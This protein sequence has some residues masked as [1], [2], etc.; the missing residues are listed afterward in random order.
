MFKYATMYGIV[1]GI[2]LI[3]WLTFDYMMGYYGQNKTMSN[4]NYLARI[5][6]T[7]ICIFIY[8]N[9]VCG[10]YIS[11][12]KAFIFGTATFL[13]A[14]VLLEIFVCLLV[15]I[16]DPTYLLIKANLMKK[17]LSEIGM[18][19]HGIRNIISLAIYMEHPIWAVIIALIG[20]TAVGSLISLISA[21]ILK[22]D[23]KESTS[24][25]KRKLRI[26]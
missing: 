18:N 5:M 26:K 2:I 14:M 24:Y 23:K 12:S 16:V 15:N 9:K 22:K 10:G 7:F 21:M 11:F 25:Q 17:Q 8:R 1:L 20:G 19:N 13:V 3:M 4:L 6:G